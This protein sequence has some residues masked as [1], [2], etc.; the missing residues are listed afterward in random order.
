MS[1]FII[2]D[3]PNIKKSLDSLNLAAFYFQIRNCSIF[4]TFSL[5]INNHFSFSQK[6]KYTP[7]RFRQWGTVVVMVI[8]RATFDM[9]NHKPTTT[10]QK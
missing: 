9:K 5:S 7:S 1:D 2:L 4:C 10:Y 3:I 6:Q 8:Y